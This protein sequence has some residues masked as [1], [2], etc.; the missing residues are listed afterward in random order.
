MNK[1]LLIGRL[2]KDAEVKAL[3]SGVKLAKFCIAVNRRGKKEEH[4]EADFIYAQ[5]WDKIA[6]LIEQYVHKGDKVG[7]VGHI[8][9]GRY[10]D[11]NGESRERFEVVVEEIEF[12]SDRKS[13]SA[14][15]PPTE[16]APPTELPFEI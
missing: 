5:A 12:L 14:P 11:K 9:T 13:D 1:V 10:Q 6:G 16:P 7:I 4:P 2:T 15:V 8:Q 3:D